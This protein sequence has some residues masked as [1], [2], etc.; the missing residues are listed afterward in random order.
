MGKTL[1]II[2][3]LLSVVVILTASFGCDKKPVSPTTYKPL[4]PAARWS[5]SFDSQNNDLGYAVQQTND[6]GYIIV[7]STTPTGTEKTDIHLIKTDNNG[8]EQWSRTFSG[9]DEMVGR[10]VQQTNDGGY[11]IVG[12][13]HLFP[14]KR[15][16]IYDGSS[17]VYLIKT[18]ENGQ[19]Q[20]SH[21]FS[22]QDVNF[23]W[24]V[25]QC[26][27]SGYIIVGTTGPTYPGKTNVYLIKTDSNGKEQWSR[28]FGGQE[29]DFG[30]S[31]WQTTDGGYVIAGRTYIFAENQT[32]VYEEKSAVYLIKTDENGLEQ[33]NSTFGQ[34]QSSGYSVQQTHDEGYIVVGFTGSLMAESDVY[35]IKTDKDGLEQ[36]SYTFADQGNNQGYSVQQTRDGGYII[37]GYTGSVSPGNTSMYLIRTD[38]N[39]RKQWSRAYNGQGIAEGNS[40][41]QTSDGGYIIVGSTGLFITDEMDVYLVKTD[42]EGKTAP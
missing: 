12:Y 40:V 35:L 14:G 10:S 6:G 17:T 16:T 4:S 18:N 37:T 1:L 41:Q 22:K 32:T 39:G 7:A 27:D 19:E 15:V 8:Q 29:D 11:I 9:Q 23:G 42:A 31:V 3:L 34:D 36:W 24:S 5:R 30:Y 20:W 2:G 33:W 28:T 25:Q 38:E 13:T 21:S 26:N